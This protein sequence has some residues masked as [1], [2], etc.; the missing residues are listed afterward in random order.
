MTDIGTTIDVVTH[1]KRVCVLALKNGRQTVTDSN[2]ARVWVSKLENVAPVPVNTS[3][4][5]QV[6]RELVSLPECQVLADLV[7]F[8]QLTAC[9][10]KD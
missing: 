2:P 5:V 6:D 1:M 3:R 8:T 4:N 10:S 7:V 9:L